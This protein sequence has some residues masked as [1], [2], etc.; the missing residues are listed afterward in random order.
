MSR[1]KLLEEATVRKFMKLANISPVNSKQFV[2]EMFGSEYDERKVEPEEEDEGMHGYGKMHDEMDEMGTYEEDEY[3][4]GKYLEEAEDE[5]KSDSEDDGGELAMTSE[6]AKKVVDALEML[7][8]KLKSATGGAGEEAPEEPAPE[9]PAPEAEAP[10]EEPAPE[11]G[12]EAPAEEEDENMMYESV[13]NKVAR[14]VAAR[15]LRESKKAP[16]K[17]V[18]KPVPPVKGKKPMKR[19]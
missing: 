7:L 5:A 9:E 4:V 14:R 11:A 1:K 2:N 8:D 12:A 13:V 3:D 17:P 18:K 6:E 10:A 15:L 19:R 16:T